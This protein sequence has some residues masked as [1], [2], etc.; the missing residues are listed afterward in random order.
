MA[1]RGQNKVLVVKD[2]Q[3]HYRNVQIMRFENDD[4]LVSNGLESGE[5]VNI[6][7]LQTVVEGM[8]VEAIVHSGK[9]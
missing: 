7:P 9:L 6:S 1:L 8:R 3:I 2:N 4:V 5:I